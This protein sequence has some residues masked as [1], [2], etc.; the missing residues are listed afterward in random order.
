MSW[1]LPSFTSGVHAEP[2]TLHLNQ[3]IRASHR[4]DEQAGLVIQ[5]EPHV[6]QGTQTDPAR[7][8]NVSTTSGKAL[9]SSLEM[10]RL[11]DLAD[12][13][14]SNAIRSLEPR[15]ENKGQI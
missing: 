13:I 14:P 12:V 6:L 11:V 7:S 5:D 8:S 10:L 2:P 15:A 1:A 4:L 9:D 3:L